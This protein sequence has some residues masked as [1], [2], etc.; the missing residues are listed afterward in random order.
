MNWSGLSDSV[1]VMALTPCPNC[2]T[3]VRLSRGLCLGCLI[4]SALDAGD[5]SP[6]D[7]LAAL[8]QAV[9]A[10]D[11]RRLGNYELL[12]EIGRGGVGGIY[13]ARERHSPRIVALQR[14]LSYHAEARE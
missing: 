4:G 10:S 2:H 11:L 8:L 5:Q 7:D 12:E 14:V 6:Q 13:R 3:I 9:P 1:A